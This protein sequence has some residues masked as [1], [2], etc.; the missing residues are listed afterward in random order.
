VS[1]QRKRTIRLYRI[2]DDGRPLLAGTLKAG[3]PAELVTLW[4]AFLA[5]A[6]RG[7]YAACYRGEILGL[8]S[9]DEAAYAALA[10]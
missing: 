6:M 8:E 10:A 1:A 3:S 5:T 7:T 9:A 2:A 4:H